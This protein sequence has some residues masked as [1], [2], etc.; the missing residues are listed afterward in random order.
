MCRIIKYIYI[1]ILILVISSCKEQEADNSL[2][3]YKNNKYGYELLAP[4]NWEKTENQNRLL[5]ATSKEINERARNLAKH[6]ETK[7]ARMDVFT[8]KFVD[9][10]SDIDFKKRIF[11]YDPIFYSAPI[12]I[13]ISGKD[14]YIYD[15]SIPLTNKDEFMEGKLLPIRRNGIAY[16]F[17]LERYGDSEGKFVN[18][19]DTI[20]KSLKINNTTQTK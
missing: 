18:L 19:F 15:I 3:L 1:Y 16:I 11:K 12:K 4:M 8:F 10:I 9:T 2:V 14:E 5:L 6:S 17:L 7:G 20:I 13:I